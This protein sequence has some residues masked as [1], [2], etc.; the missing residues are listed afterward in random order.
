MS[1]QL[2]IVGTGN[3]GTR[4][5]GSLLHAAFPDSWGSV[6]YHYEPLYWTGGVDA[7]NLRLCDD[8]LREHVSY[9]L[10]PISEG[11]GWPWM[12]DFIRSRS[13]VAKFIRAGSRIRQFFQECPRVIW[14]T[15]ELDGYLASMQK[16]FPRCENAGGWH[17]RPGRYD[18]LA[19]LKHLYPES[20]SDCTEG[21][22]VVAEAAWWH[23]QNRDFPDYLGDPRLYFL[24]YERLC[25]E[26]LEVLRE[27]AGFLDC[28]AVEDA[29]VG[30]ASS[31]RAPKPYPLDL[32]D[33]RRH[34]IDRIAGELNGRLFGG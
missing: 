22:R 7:A 29:L 3:S 5:L 11:E 23:V 30:A 13:G 15:R 34:R 31:V 16:N 33:A 1:L 32:T 20:L 27:L 21:D 2:L 18:D 24:P 26:P 9:P 17:H 4:L 6:P 28:E 12:S 14:I 19:R 10:R 25:S 8:G